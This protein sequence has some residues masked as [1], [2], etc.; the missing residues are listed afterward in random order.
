MSIIQIAVG[1]VGHKV[2]IDQHEDSYGFGFSRV[3]PRFESCLGLW[4]C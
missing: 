4:D 2:V 3:Q 1:P